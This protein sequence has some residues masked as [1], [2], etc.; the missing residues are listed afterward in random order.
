MLVEGEKKRG[1]VWVRFKSGCALRVCSHHA[2]V[3]HHVLGS[4]H[5]FTGLAN[6][7]N[8]KRVLCYS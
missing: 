1:W 8:G 4:E 7:Q 2:R 3:R 5:F 6:W